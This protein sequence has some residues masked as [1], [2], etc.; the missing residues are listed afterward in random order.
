MPRCFLC[1]LCA[2]AVNQ[3]LTHLHQVSGVKA[4]SG[5]CLSIRVRDRG[6]G[7]VAQDQKHIF[8][9]FYRGGGEIARQ[10][11]GV[12]LGLSLVKPVLR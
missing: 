4:A 1:V 3:N 5:A 9:K 10:V 11:K 2:S 6:L 8:E 12:G 7:I